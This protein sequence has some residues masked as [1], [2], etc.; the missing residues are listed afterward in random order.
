MRPRTSFRISTPD[1]SAVSFEGAVPL[2]PKVSIP[3]GQSPAQALGIEK[4]QSV[5]V[6]VER[7]EERN[8]RLAKEKE[9]R[10][11][12]EKEE[13]E[14]KEEKDMLEQERRE[15]EE[16]ERVEREEQERVEEEEAK[17]KAEAEAKAK[18]ELKAKEKEEAEAKAKAAAEAIEA[19][20]KADAEAAAKAAAEVKEQAKAEAADATTAET[21][22]NATP[23][24]PPKPTCNGLLPNTIPE[25]PSP[26]SISATASERPKYPAPNLSKLAN[27]PSGPSSSFSKETPKQHNAILSSANSSTGV[28]T[29]PVV[30]D[31]NMYQRSD[32]S[33][34]SISDGTEAEQG[35]DEEDALEP[36]APVAISKT[37]VQ[38]KVNDYIKVFRRLS[39]H[40]S[41]WLT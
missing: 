28:F 17:L 12:K 14:K 10:E 39:I 5:T 30:E 34:R 36:P 41:W 1:G 3:M 20:A 24:D 29:L 26:L 9:G 22:D 18:A 23:V 38:K 13:R 2:S 32:P 16:R 6:R 31:E 19:K 15:R 40:L 8:A 11:K 33:P 7:E 35:T 21:R 25:R 37:V 4:R 27:P